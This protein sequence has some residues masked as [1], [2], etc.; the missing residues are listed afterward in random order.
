MPEILKAF[1][2]AGGF[3]PHGHCYLWQPELVWL[4][5]ASDSLIALAYYSISIMLVYFVR[6]RRDVPFD[7][8]FLMFG[9]FIIA[10]G[11]THL[12]EVWTLWH[13]TYWVSGFVKAIT[14]LVS[15]CTA[16]LLVP[17]IPKAMALPSPAQLETTNRAL[18]KEIAQRQLTESAL[19][20]SEERLQRANEELEIR[21]QNRTAQLALLNKSLQAEIAE[22]KQTEEE[23]RESERRFQVLA[24]ATSEGIVIQEMGKVL[25]ANPSFARMFGYD[26]GEVIGMSAKDF[27]TPESLALVMEKTASGDEKPYEVTGLK[28]DGTTFP[29]EVQGR[30]CIYQ[31]RSVRVSSGRELTEQKRVEETLN[32]SQQ[33]F[34]ALVENAPDIISRVDRELRHV[35]VNPAIEPATGLLRETFIGKTH[36][37]LGMSEELVSHWESVIRKV[38]E[39]GQE[40]VIEFQFPTPTGRKYYQ[41]RIVPEWGKDG[42]IESILGIARDITKKKGTEAALRESEQ[43]F[44]A[45]FAQAAVGIIQARIDGSLLLVNQKFCEIV[46][47][48][49]EELLEKTF[50]DITHSDDHQVDLKYIDQMVAGEISTNYREKRYIH[51]DGS[52][53]WINLSVSL[54]RSSLG[55]PE[56]LLGIIEDISDRKRVE[57]ALKQT[58]FCVDSATDAIAWIEPPNARFIYVNDA[59]CRSLGYSRSELLSMCV[60]DIDPDVSSTVCDE[61]WQALKQQS[62]LKFESRQRRKDGSIFPV[63]IVSNYV[64]FN[65][66][67]YACCFMRDLTS[68]K[69]REQELHLLQ[70]ITQGISEAPDFNSALRVALCKV[71]EVTGWNFAEVWIPNRQENILDL[72]PVWCSSVKGQCNYPESL[73]QFRRESEK[74]TFSLHSGLPGR[75]WASKQPEWIQDVYLQPETI[76]LRSQMAQ[77]AGLKAAIGVPIIANV[78]DV[79]VPETQVL[80][81][82]VFFTFESCEEDKRLV[83]LVSSV[84]NQLGLVIQRKRAEAELWQTNQKLQA[85]IQSAPVSIDILDLEGNVLL[86]NP[87]AE[88]LFGWSEKEVIG[89]PL[90]RV[91]L[92]KW[93]KFQAFLRALPQGEN[94]YTGSEVQCQKKDGSTVDI[95]LSV[96]LLRDVEGEIIGQI[97]I[98][99]DISDRK[100][101][102]DA[103]RESENH[104][105]TII[106]AQPECVKMVAPDGNVLEMNA[107]GLNMIEVDTADQVI[108]QSVYSLVVPEYREAYKA[109]NESVCQG[110]KQTLEFELI[111]CK[112]TRRWMETHAVPLRHQLDGTLVQLAITRDITERKRAEQAILELNETLERR[113]TERTTELE[114]ANKELEAFSYSVSH[115]LRAPLRG[116]DGFSQA[117]LDRYADKLDD[118]GK[119]YLQRIRAGTQRMGELIDDLL[120]LS[121]VT[122]SEMRRTPVDLSAL[123]QEIAQELQQTQPSRQVEWAIAPGLIVDGDAR[124]LRI[125]LENLLTNAWKFT[126][127]RLHSRIELDVLPQEE[128]KLAYFVRDNGAG[129]DMIHA[130][131]LF[132]PFQRLHNTSQFPG[133]GIGL[134]TVQRV[135]HRHGGQVWAQGALDVGATFYFTL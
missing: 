37:E 4:H 84:A 23:L 12:L 30:N 41:S 117:L 45:I 71:C 7:W 20:E 63:E 72:S 131:K 86:W 21:V 103:L 38:F 78:S 81:I 28:K 57:Q 65:G 29:I 80:A 24:E 135:I 89:R 124:L 44:R 79:T 129:F 67:E 6:Q 100:R 108:G 52:I 59:V 94:P 35:Y 95:N 112:G 16:V 83:E 9:T 14:A 73:K 114:A 87:A 42:A 125:V 120:Q 69:Q 26:R 32:R 25:D 66:L 98:A 76:F 70:T 61:L 90:P 8:I 1:L 13:P 55:E 77:K 3:I 97:S 18:R 99:I 102:E 46:G 85:L 122:R 17:L 33:E 15:L 39:T 51:K 64:N 58:Q 31:G 113:V 10:C 47:Y 82:F 5:V 43:R 128:N 92:D 49:R 119:H 111:G 54:I 110:N 50:H 36:R 62:S 48:S 121:R 40:E 22:H 2:S 19:E 34:K 115:D 132:G 75:V 68:R 11:T 109:F 60:P 107:A 106:E 104:L 123:A 91:S 133:T 96:A 93:D 118:K 101:A 105:R 88:R 116:I 126:S 127:S 27:L 53:V 74:L 130:N 56:Y 134:A